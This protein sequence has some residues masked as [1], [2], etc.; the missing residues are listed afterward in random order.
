MI[1]IL[2]D[3]FKSAGRRVVPFPAGGNPGLGDFLSPAQEPS[4]LLAQADDHGGFAVLE[5]G[6]IGND[7]IVDRAAT[8]KEQ[9]EDGEETREEPFHGAENG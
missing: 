1:L 7:E 9:R 8:T 2:S 3:H 4:A 5:A 6:D